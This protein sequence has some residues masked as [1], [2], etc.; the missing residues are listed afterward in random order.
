VKAIFDTNVVIYLQKGLLVR[1]LP[2]GEYLLSVISE[3][4]LRS[5]H[6]LDATSQS[7]LNAFL[8]EISIVELDEQVK[9]NTVR[10]RRMHRLRL[11]DA[12]IAASAVAHDA[13]LLT[14]DQRLLTIPEVQSEAL[15][16]RHE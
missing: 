15:D 7:W 4:E 3:L 14:N 10:L 12:I 8:A 11:P 2:R 1:S 5:F 16:L 9:V 13:I 6:G